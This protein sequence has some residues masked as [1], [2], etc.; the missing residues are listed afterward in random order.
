MLVIPDLTCLIKIYLYAIIT[1][2][3]EHLRSYIRSTA[4][5]SQYCA[6]DIRDFVVQILTPH[7]HTNTAEAFNYHWLYN[8]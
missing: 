2:P 8:P 6:R 5:W 3:W 1:R 7:M 4:V